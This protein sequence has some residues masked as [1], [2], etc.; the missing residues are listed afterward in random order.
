M[1]QAAEAAYDK[2]VRDEHFMDFPFP[3]VIRNDCKT[4][5]KTMQ[6]HKK[7]HLRNFDSEPINHTSLLHVYREIRHKYKFQIIGEILF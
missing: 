4:T 6:I 2:A 1:G 7:I 3:Y 5:I